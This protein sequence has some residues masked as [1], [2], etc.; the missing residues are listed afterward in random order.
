MNHEKIAEL[1]HNLVE[2][3]KFMLSQEL[4]FQSTELKT[5]EITIIQRVF[6][7]YE[8]SRDAMTLGILPLRFWY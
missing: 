2:N 8:V 3:P 6:S 1:F 4:G 5:N 7:E